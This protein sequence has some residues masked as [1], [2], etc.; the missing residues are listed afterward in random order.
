[1][2]CIV[3]AG[4]S[5]SKHMLI[6]MNEWKCE[7]CVFIE[8]PL[9]IMIALVH[10][11]YYLDKNVAADADRIILVIYVIMSRR[12]SHLMRGPFDTQS[13][14]ANLNNEKSYYLTL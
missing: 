14:Y 4:K 1:M 12:E 11:N 2:G 9:I 3:E 6:V 7:H 8:T 13:C 10:D 5:V